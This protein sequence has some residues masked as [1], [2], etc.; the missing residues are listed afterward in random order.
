V[1]RHGGGITLGLGV[2]PTASIQLTAASEAVVAGQHYALSA[3][4]LLVSGCQHVGPSCGPA[5]LFVLLG[6][7]GAALARRLASRL[8]FERQ[9]RLAGAAAR[10]LG[11]ARLG[12]RTV[13]V[14][15]SGGPELCPVPLAG[16]W[17]RPYVCFP[18]SG[19]FGQL[20]P[21]RGALVSP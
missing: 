11:T 14:Y 4:D 3:G 18:R 12:W 6:L 2:R 16:G 17:V 10:S 21:S 7:G 5:L 13:D 15:L 19:Y 8:R 20:T 1:V 9:Q